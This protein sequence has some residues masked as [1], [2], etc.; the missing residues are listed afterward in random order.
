MVAVGS[1]S[2]AEGGA[3]GERPSTEQTQWLMMSKNAA[4]AK[5]KELESQ[6][7]STREELAKRDIRFVQ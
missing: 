2:A 5:C 7:K 6:L 1:G 3:A 4:Q